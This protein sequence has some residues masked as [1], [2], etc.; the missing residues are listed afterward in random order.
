MYADD[1][2]IYTQAQNIQQ[3]AAD[4]TPKKLAQVVLPK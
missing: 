3:A 4:L 1:A 2:V